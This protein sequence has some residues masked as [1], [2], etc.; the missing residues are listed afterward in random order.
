MPESL[1]APE[2]KLLKVPENIHSILIN[3]GAPPPKGELASL[4]NYLKVDGATGLQVIS[5]GR[6]LKIVHIF[7]DGR[8]E[9]V[10]TPIPLAVKFGWVTLEVEKDQKNFAVCLLWKFHGGPCQRRSQ[11]CG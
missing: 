9:E 4:E 7:P 8:Q 2:E 3:N 5:D 6:I 10:L 11:R 1:I